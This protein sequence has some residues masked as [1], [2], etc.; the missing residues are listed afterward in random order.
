MRYYSSGNGLALLC[1]G[2]PTLKLVPTSIAA[3]PAGRS[4]LGVAVV[5]PP[6][7]SGYLMPATKQQ[8]HMLPF[9]ALPLCCAVAMVATL[10]DTKDNVACKSN[11]PCF[12]ASGIGPT[13]VNS[14]LWDVP[15]LH[16]LSELR[17]AYEELMS[18]P[19][20]EFAMQGSK[21]KAKQEHCKNDTLDTTEALRQFAQ[22]QMMTTDTFKDEQVLDP[23]E[24]LYEFA[25]MQT[26]ARR[27]QQNGR[28]C[29]NSEM[30]PI[31]ALFELA[32]LGQIS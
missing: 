22:M 2:F 9:A 19:F 23:S 25:Q 14:Q 6:S 27:H 29:E 16:A 24:A 13:S 4:M 26:G 30:D 11:S 15:V 8:A 28:P 32:S 31:E 12:P 17:S 5:P 1:D 21:G 3:L 7:L 10:G 20:W 18:D